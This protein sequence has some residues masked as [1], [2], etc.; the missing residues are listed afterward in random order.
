MAETKPDE[1]SRLQKEFDLLRQTRDELRVQLYLGAVEAEDAWDRVEG[2]WYQLE[3]R[4][5]RIFEA[6]HDATEDVEEATRLLFEEVKE[7]YDRV[8]RAL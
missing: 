4:V 5:K 8:K 7:G 6:A 1:R 3:S 2:S